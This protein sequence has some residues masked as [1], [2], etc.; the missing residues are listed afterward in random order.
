MRNFLLKKFQDFVCADINVI[1]GFFPTSS[2]LNWNLKLT[3]IGSTKP[4]IV[5]VIEALNL[6]SSHIYYLH[7]LYFV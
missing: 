2:R 5:S 4:T 1:E 7:I 6:E 3:F